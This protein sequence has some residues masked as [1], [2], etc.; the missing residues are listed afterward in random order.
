MPLLKAGPSPPPSTEEVPMSKFLLAILAL[1]LL[2]PALRA[3]D[4]AEPRQKVIVVVG[5]PGN[6]EYARNFSQWA[7]AGQPPPAKPTPSW[8]GSALG[9]KQK[10]PM[11]Q[12]TAQ[13]LQQTLAGLKG[14]KSAAVWLVLIGHGT[15]DGQRAK[16]NLRGPDVA[17]EELAE[18]LKPLSMPLAVVNCAS[19][20]GPF[21]N[22]LSGENRVIVTATKSGYELN[23][24]RFGE[25]I[26]AAIADPKADLDKDGQTSL[27]E[28][29]LAASAAAQ[30]FYK[31]ESRL[32][33]EHALIDD[34]GDALGT[35]SDWFQGFRAVRTAKEGTMPD[36]SRANQ[37]VLVPG[38]DDEKLTAERKIRR[39]ELGTENR[40]LAIAE[41][42]TPRG[43]LLP[44]LGAV[45]VEPGPVVSSS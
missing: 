18:W 11:S 15:F 5:T 14:S 37:F 34:N 22:R 6:E 29:F 2:A 27:L 30:D 16:F 1:L 13:F 41:T 28:A 43:R 19:A 8:C 24:A 40:P 33:T 4:I 25:H 32:A 12:T 42:A 39:D 3:A 10:I 7:A 44:P 38:K 21:I 20:S 31:Q 9:R 17:A 45:A 23:Y 36:G 26:S 35:P